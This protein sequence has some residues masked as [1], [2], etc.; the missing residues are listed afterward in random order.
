VFVS[1]ARLPARGGATADDEVVHL[2][3]WGSTRLSGDAECGRGLRR[4]HSLE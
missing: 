1:G 3:E 4:R 2:M